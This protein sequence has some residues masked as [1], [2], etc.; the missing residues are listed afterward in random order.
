MPETKGYGRMKKHRDRNT[1]SFSG[2]QF[3]RHYRSHLD[4]LSPENL[5]VDKTFIPPINSADKVLDYFC[6]DHSVLTE[7]WSFM[8]WVF[9]SHG[10][11]YNRD[12]ERL[13]FSTLQTL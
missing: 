8:N 3:L 4:D 13:T 12:I 9:C 1:N 10:I 2:V 5:T 7:A 6:F 11:S